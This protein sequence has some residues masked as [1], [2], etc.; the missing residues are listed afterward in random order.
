VR[1]L[2]ESSKYE[3]GFAGFWKIWVPATIFNIHAHV[4]A[5]SCVAATFAVL[6]HGPPA[7]AGMLKCSDMAGCRNGATYQVWRKD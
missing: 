7:D 6:D 2:N 5:Y 1:V 4:G 3:R